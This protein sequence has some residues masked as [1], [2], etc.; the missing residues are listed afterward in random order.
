M[1]LMAAVDDNMG[2]MFNHRRQSRDRLLRQR[3]LA[4]A[5]DRTL[6]MDR[7]SA[8]LFGAELDGHTVRVEE[9]F[10]AQAAPGDFCFLED[11]SPR[12]AEENIEQVVL[13][14]W[15]RTYPA[16][17]HFDLD[18]SCWTLTCSEDFPGSS[19]DK[20]TQEVYTRA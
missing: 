18:L 9:D 12:P 19:H 8:A 7:Y 15:N 14:R 5:G 4:L 16:D 10:L 6:W 13:F 20:I 17:L 1:I 2:L 3:I 11:R